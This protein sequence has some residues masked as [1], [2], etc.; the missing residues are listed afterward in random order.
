MSL[1]DVGEVTAVT[2]TAAA[3][4]LKCTFDTSDLMLVGQIY[5]AVLAWCRK[6]IGVESLLIN[7]VVEFISYMRNSRHCSI[8]GV[9]IVRSDVLFSIAGGLVLLLLVQLM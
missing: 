2:R 5:I 9:A 4:G 8:S 3:T 1:V 6:T 7:S